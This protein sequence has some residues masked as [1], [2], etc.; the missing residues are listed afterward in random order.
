MN[1]T[2]HLGVD[3]Q[4]NYIP[5][6]FLSRTGQRDQATIDLLSA[7]V[8]NP[9]AGLFPSGNLNGSVVARSQLLKP[10]PQYTNVTAE[11]VSDGSLYSHMLVARIDK[12]LASG[13]QFQSNFEYS[14]V[15]QKLDRLN[16]S[17]LSPY[18]RVSSTDRP[19]RLVTSG[20]Y[21]LPFGRGKHFAA[22]ANR[23]VNQF[24]GGW[25]VSGVY[26]AQAGPP[27]EWGDGIYLG[28]DLRWSPTSIDNV[29]DTTRFVTRSNQQ[30]GSNL[31]TFPITFSN[32]RAPAITS[33]DLAVMKDFPIHE[34]L[35]LQYRC[36]FFNALNHPIFD[37][38]D[39]SPTSSTFG[40]TQAQINLPRS[41]QMSLKL[42][43]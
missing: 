13:L 27:V 36:E 12:R 14:R 22:S 3:H 31:R 10:F 16:D 28:G 7:S 42:A 4:I 34:R 35:K 8:T 37:V 43:W 21:S 32:L 30:L 23:V 39:V 24:V 41:I 19:L 29:F 11:Q 26:V 2:V 38:P 17:D 5:A 1:H 40:R 25:L 9:F 6:Q 33:V 18:K 15:M 20:L